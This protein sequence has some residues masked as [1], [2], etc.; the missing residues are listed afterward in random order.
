VAIVV[1]VL[2]A[3]GAILSVSDVGPGG[4]GTF[5]S[6][7]R[8]RNGVPTGRPPAI[9]RDG[10]SAR[11][12][13]AAPRTWD[14][15]YAPDAATAATLAQVYEGLTAFDTESR[16]QPALASDWTVEDGGRRIVFQLRPDI[17]F[18]DDTPITSTDVV[19][20][21]LRLIDP[22]APGPLASLLSDVDG[23]IQ[24][25][26]GE[27]A[28]E[29]VGLQAD[30]D[31]VIV[32]FRRPAA[33]FVAVTAS[34]SLAVLPAASAEGRV[35]AELP[36]D[37]VVSG[38]YV[39][40]A[41]DEDSITLDPN[42]AYWAG[43]PHIARIEVVTDTQGRSAVALFEAGEVDWTNIGNFDASWIAY[44]P[45]LGPQLRR[46]DS[47]SVEYYGFDTTRPPFDDA[48]VRR[49]FSQAVDWDRAVL[50]AVDSEPATSLI[51]AGIPGR[52][53]EDFTPVHDP[54]AAR[55]AL[56][57]A[58]YPE[59]EGFPPVTLTS[60]GMAYD[61]AIAQELRDELGVEVDLEIR[62]FDEYTTLL[63]TDPPQFWGL[64][65]IADYPAPQDF[66]GLLLESGS[67]S[68]EGRWS[69][70]AFDAALEA[71]AATDDPAEQAEH[72]AEAQTIVRDQAPVIPVAYGETWALS[73]DGLLGAGESG[74]GFVRYAGMSW[75]ASP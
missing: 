61:Q 21:W 39:P 44:D 74:V 64:T 52:S 75:E 66:L 60:E 5:G 38:A 33:Y 29:D 59:G 13:G 71:A 1:V 27:V 51:P 6:S 65:W 69:D 9:P 28:R 16:V 26:R 17:R 72:Y 68:N 19:E 46:A 53:E 7:P 43:P 42:V 40:V 18:S 63:D 23:A 34:P 36:R 15:A 54:D 11:L 55:A 14:P 3:F 32:E 45:V 10:T 25:A 24:Y 73:R 57:E 8:P 4:P 62:P 56:A 47:F 58:G 12:V 70:A 30:G 31:R 67:S 48:S 41:Q 50:L 49:A 37:M 22:E 20:S 2:I 35:G